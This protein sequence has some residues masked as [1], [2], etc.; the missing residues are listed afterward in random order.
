MTILITFKKL[1]EKITDIRRASG[2]PVVPDSFFLCR[3]ENILLTE[4]LTIRKLRHI[5]K[6]MQNLKN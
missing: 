1:T 3:V 4:V 2:K 6:N 5:E